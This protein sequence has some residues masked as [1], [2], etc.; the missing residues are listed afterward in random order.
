MEKMKRRSH[1]AVAAE[2]SHFHF[3]DDCMFGADA[4]QGGAVGAVG[5]VGQL[6]GH[7]IANFLKKKKKKKSAQLL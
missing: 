4:A 3:S 5:V 2:G 7:R 1:G 6:V